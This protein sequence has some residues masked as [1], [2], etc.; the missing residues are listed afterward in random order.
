MPAKKSTYRPSIESLEDR[1]VP[2]TA[3]LSGGIL[4]VIG[5]A[6]S[7]AIT[8]S[9]AGA[10]LKVS[11]V[12][13]SFHASA[14]HAI[15]ING[16][17]G[18]HFI[19]IDARLTTPVVV[20]CGAG[21]DVILGDAGNNT[22]I[23]SGHITFI[24]R[25]GHNV[26]NG[27]PDWIP[28][29]QPA[30]NPGPGFGLTD[31]ADNPVVAFCKS[32][33]HQKVGGGECAHLANEALR[34][35]GYDFAVHDPGNNGDYTWGTLLT[36]ITSGRDSSPSAAC[37]PGD[38]IQFQN[39]VLSNGWSASQ[40]TAVVA[41][42]DSHGRPTQVYEQNVG[43]NGK[44]KESGV[45]DRTDRLDPL[46]INLSTVSSGTIHIYR[47]VPRSDSAGTVQFSVV[48]NTAQG[49]TVTVY[50]NGA[51]QWTI[52]LDSFNTAGSYQ[53]ASG[54][55]SGRGNWSIGING[56]MVAL[57]NAGGYEVFTAAN[58]QTSIRAI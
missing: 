27:V 37:R 42:V 19:D 54:W 18:N 50:F 38:I 7:D 49:Q 43:V 46:A 30:V 44:G 8:V 24:G 33:L 28:S 25:G 6:R 51:S 29:N 1:S 36:T 17:G 26:I 14:V 15:V 41:A 32:H 53:T 23:G 35:A 39:V 34:V 48:N 57:T 31:S 9:L 10:N 2:T 13:R 47:P 5:T 55:A 4:N 40:H 52:S 11:G 3:G 22:V 56:R 20:L 12:K 58:G 21:N 45:H 16:G